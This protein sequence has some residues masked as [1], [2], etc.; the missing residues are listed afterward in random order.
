MLP[1][2]AGTAGANCLVDVK[3][4]VAADANAA[5]DACLLFRP[6]QHWAGAWKSFDAA[7][8][9]NAVLRC[10]SRSDADG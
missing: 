1:S 9:R 3:D 2:T 7:R 8:V 4:K 5:A 10:I 6:D